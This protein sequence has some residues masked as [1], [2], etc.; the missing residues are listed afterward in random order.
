[1]ATQRDRW[2]PLPSRAVRK[3]MKAIE[4]TSFGAPEVL[5]LVERPDPVAGAG[6]LLIEAAGGKVSGSD[7]A[8]SSRTLAE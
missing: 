1:M 4:I 2:S 7:P 5:R 8:S 3:T 6:E